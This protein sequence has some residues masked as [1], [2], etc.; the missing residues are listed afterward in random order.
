MST[1]ISC[2]QWYFIPVLENISSHSGKNLKKL[3]EYVSDFR[4][5]VY[6][7]IALKKEDRLIPG[8]ET[9]LILF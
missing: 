2:P 5:E 4:F 1:G 7:M 8:Y 3:F 9:I 6:F